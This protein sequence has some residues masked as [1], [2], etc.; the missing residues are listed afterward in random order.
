MGCKNTFD[1]CL[2]I[3]RGLSGQPEAI[4]S[5]SDTWLSRGS[6]GVLGNHH[7][8]FPEMKPLKMLREL[9]HVLVAVCSRY[10]VDGGK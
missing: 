5:I 3:V 8:A 9:E 6:A 1:N 7:L 10:P 2:E 4:F